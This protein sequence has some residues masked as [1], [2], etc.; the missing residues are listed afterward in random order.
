MTLSAIVLLTD[1]GGSTF[2]WWSPVSYGLGAIAVVSLVGFIAVERRVK[3]PVL[4]LDLFSNRTFALTAGIRLIVGLALFGT[5]TYL[6]LFLQVVDGQSPTSSG[7]QL[8]PRMGGMRIT[9]IASGQII[10][11]RGCYKI[12]PVVGT[13]RMDMHTTIEHASRPPSRSSRG[14]CR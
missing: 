1:L 9:S 8:L 12:F 10:S 4:P 11:R 14:R 2:P 13:A 7:L 6:P 5:V 3:E